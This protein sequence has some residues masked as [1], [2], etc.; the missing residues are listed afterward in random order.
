MNQSY[1]DITISNAWYARA[2][3]IMFPVTQTMAKG[4]SQYVNGVAPKYLS[5]GKD[6][7][8]W[9]VD[10]NEYIDF[11]MGIGP[12][13]LGYGY[14]AVDNA[15]KK[16]LE[17]GIT[18]SLMH[19]LEVELS[20]LIHRIIPN[21]EAVRIAKTGAEVCSAAVRISR[22]FTGRKK[23]LC[24]G[25]HGW[26]DWY[27]GTT[28]RAE[29]IP[30]EIKDLSATFD[31]NNIESLKTKLDDDVACVI[32]EPFIFEAP[33]DNFLEKVQALC[34]A[35][36]TLLIFDEM[37][38]GFRVAVGGAQ[39]YFGI[40]PD[41]AVYSKAFANGMPI[42]LLTGRKDVMKLF[43]KDVFFYSTFGGEALSMAAAMATIHEMIEKNVP[44]ALAAK[45]KTLRE[46]YNV[47][48]A[49]HHLSSVT[50]CQGF[51]CRTIITFNASAGDP[52]ILKSFVQQEM[53][54]RGVLWGGFHNVC[55]THT[56]EDI[57]KTLAAYDEVL[58]LLASALN[59]NSVAQQLR[60][61]PVEAVFRKV[62]DVQ[63]TFK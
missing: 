4:P 47:L 32:L 15:I 1:P 29:G 3:Q 31:Y 6:G 20:E 7:H 59:E 2:K 28:S 53:I 30:Q 19:P 56:D 40:T 60:G 52:L 33:K 44:A 36:G 21:A 46:G 63:K 17:D 18:F 38:T 39:E 62:G 50:T 26:H 10:G 12:I 34:Q 22:A 35:N 48:V 57:E 11:N 43:E 9:D 24:C 45:G 61:K 13:S 55:F 51:D 58:A 27:I 16:Q 8:V 14:V 37:W 49:K 54:K 5:R 25:Y 42:A 23:V 41:L